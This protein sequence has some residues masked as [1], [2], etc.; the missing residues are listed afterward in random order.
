MNHVMY[1]C[2]K[3]K[4]CGH[5]ND[6]GKDQRH[7]DNFDEICNG[8]MVAY[9]PQS[10]L[11]ALQAKMEKAIEAL[12]L[13]KEHCLCERFKTK[14]FDYQQN[15]TNLGKPRGGSRWNTPKDI[16]EE[17]LKELEAE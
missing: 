15:H 5:E 14:G 12:K 2:S 10:T 13:A 17:A 8:T 6:S 9:V 1:F 7:Y 16:I 4:A 3:Y 11:T